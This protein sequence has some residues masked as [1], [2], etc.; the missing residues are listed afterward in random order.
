MNATPGER[1]QYW[2]R[3]LASED[4]RRGWYE[5]LERLGFFSPMV[6][7]DATGRLDEQQTMVRVF[8]REAA[9]DGLMEALDLVPKLVTASIVE[10]LAPDGAEAEE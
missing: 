3:R 6:A 9:V 7:Y 5:D 1:R 8:R 4:L 2:E 10:S